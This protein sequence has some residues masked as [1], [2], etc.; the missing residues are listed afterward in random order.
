[1]SEEARM[2][3]ESYGRDCASNPHMNGRNEAKAALLAYITR[4]ERERCTCDEET[5]IHDPMC[6][7]AVRET[8]RAMQARI[9]ALEAENT[10]LRTAFTEN[11]SENERLTALVQEL[12]AENARLR[13]NSERYE[14]LCANAYVWGSHFASTH[15]D[16]V[17]DVALW[18]KG[19]VA[20]DQDGISEAIDAARKP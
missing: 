17:E 8:A 19:R 13:A 16:Q 11:E 6:V 10:T 5:G 7:L 12:E 3:V 2:L 4:I 1:M 18:M 20:M 14:W 9:A 15:D